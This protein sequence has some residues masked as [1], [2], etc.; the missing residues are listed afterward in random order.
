MT[1]T[2][3][4][5]NYYICILLKTIDLFFIENVIIWKIIVDIYDRE[6]KNK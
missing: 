2:E 6:R 3:I 5:K 4:K 1:K